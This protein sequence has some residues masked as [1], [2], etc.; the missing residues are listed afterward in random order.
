MYIRNS[1]KAGDGRPPTPAPDV[2]DVP[3]NGL[4]GLWHGSIVAWPSGCA[5][6]SSALLPLPTTDT[7]AISTPIRGRVVAIPLTIASLTHAAC[8]W[9]IGLSSRFGGDWRPSL[10]P[11]PFGPPRTAEGVKGTRAQPNHVLVGMER[12]LCTHLEDR[13]LMLHLACKQRARPLD[14]GGGAKMWFETASRPA[15]PL[16]AGGGGTARA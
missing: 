9:D 2:G 3:H 11:A 7:T 12:R 8:D 14:W 13:R 1:T 5:L 4:P 10:C 16:S 6:H 15:A